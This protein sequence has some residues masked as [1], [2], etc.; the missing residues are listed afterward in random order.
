[1]SPDP[2]TSRRT[3]GEPVPTQ[4]ACTWRRGVT[5]TAPSKTTAGATG[6]SL[7]VGA[8]VWGAGADAGSSAPQADRAKENPSTAGAIQPRA[9]LVCPEVL[10]ASHSTSRPMA[11]T[12]PARAGTRRRRRRRSTIGA[13]TGL[14]LRR[15]VLT[16]GPRPGGC[17]GA[18][19]IPAVRGDHI[20]VSTACAGPSATASATLVDRGA[21]QVG[22]VVHTIRAALR[23]CAE[24]LGVEVE[25]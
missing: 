13:T 23:A 6:V 15:D 16:G 2:P 4:C 25:M 17:G 11:G 1:M 19:S 5:S 22:P 21:W 14:L 3:V 12:V 8:E 9:R 24:E 7:A 10:P 20:R 18:P